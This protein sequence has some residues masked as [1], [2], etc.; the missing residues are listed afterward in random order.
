V[1]AFLILD[2]FVPAA[3]LAR[4]NRM[5]LPCPY[6]FPAELRRATYRE[7]RMKLLFPTARRSF[8]AVVLKNAYSRWNSPC[9]IRSYLCVWHFPQPSEII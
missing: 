4:A 3:S 6:D 7:H 1:N 9:V 2:A 5:P 8:S